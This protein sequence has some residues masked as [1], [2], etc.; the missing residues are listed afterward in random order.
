MIVFL[1]RL[2]LLALATQVAFRTLKTLRYER[3]LAGLSDGAV[4]YR[5]RRAVLVFA[6]WSAVV[7]FA[8]GGLSY[9]DERFQLIAKVAVNAET[10]LLFV[11]LLSLLRSWGEHPE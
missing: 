4:G 8:I 2:L 5:N 1:F 6:L 7:A 9:V 3:R 11:V 10:V